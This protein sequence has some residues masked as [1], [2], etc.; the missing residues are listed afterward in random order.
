MSQQSKNQEVK[1]KII[2][3]LAPHRTASTWLFNTLLQALRQTSGEPAHEY[4]KLTV[5]VALAKAEAAS[6]NG[7][8]PS[9]IL[10]KAHHEPSLETIRFMRDHFD[11]RIVS[12]LRSGRGIA[13]SWMRVLGSPNFE[14]DRPLRRVFTV[15]HRLADL[16]RLG[17]QPLLISDAEVAKNQPATYRKILKFVGIP[18]DA[19]LLQDL[20]RSNSREKNWVKVSELEQSFETKTFESFDQETHW[21][22][23]HVSFQSN[24]D[25]EQLPSSV[26]DDIDLIDRLNTEIKRLEF[27]STLSRRRV[28]IAPIETLEGE[29]RLQALGRLAE[30][31]SR[32]P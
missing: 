8:E 17:F 20:A 6:G 9:V 1:P 5:F 26:Q 27:W 2:L 31:D 14:A 18:S 22:A 13:N 4:W 7:Q 23:K 10:L 12:T 24:D 25:S 21:H 15:Q 30:I 11:L 28:S 29:T 16:L 19:A 32:L 3:V